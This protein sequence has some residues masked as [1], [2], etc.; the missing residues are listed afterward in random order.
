MAIGKASDFKVYQEEFMGGFVEAVEQETNVFNGASNGSIRLIPNRLK[1]DYEK[2]SFFKS[3]SGIVSRRDT[4]SVAGVTDLA[5]TQGEFVSVKVNRKIGPVANTLDSFRKIAAD[6]QE[7]SFILGQQWGKAAAKDYVDVALGGV[8]AAIAGQVSLVN[9][10]TAAATT[11]VSHASMVGCMAKLGDQ[12]SRIV[13][14]VMHSK[15]FFDLMG[16][17]IA[18]KIFEVAG[19]TIYSGTVATFNRP[20]IVTDSSS[21]VVDLAT[22]QYRT[23]ALVDGAVTVEESET[24]EIVSD[25]VTGLE[26]LVLRVQG[27]YAYNVGVKGF[28]WDVTNGAANPTNAAILTS[29]NWDLVVADVKSG[30]GAMLLSL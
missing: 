25:L 8:G 30:P 21:L 6:P 5:L 19:V 12:S 26:N 10:I 11:T 1:G 17:A 23:L 29:T 16:A 28:Q 4:T 2:E 22:D 3:I 24:R 9:D 27:E 14:F 18:D 7:F 20:V 15:P 13:A